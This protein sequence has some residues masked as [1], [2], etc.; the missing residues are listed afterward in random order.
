MIRFPPVEHHIENRADARLCNGRAASDAD[1]SSAD[2]YALRDARMA[3][4]L[5]SDVPI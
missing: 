1:I 2:W 5:C 3:A 4:T